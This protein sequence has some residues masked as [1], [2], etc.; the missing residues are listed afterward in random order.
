MPLASNPELRNLLTEIK[1]AH[2]QIIDTVSADRLLEAGPSPEATEKA[3]KTVAS[4]QEFIR[5][6]RDEITAL[7]VLYSRPYRQRLRNEDIHDL[8]DMLKSPPRGWTEQTLWDAYRR[9]DGS[10]VRGSG[11][12][13]LTDIV[14]LVR[15]AVGQDDELVPFADRVRERFAEWMA[16]Q[17]VNARPFTDEQRRWLEAIRDQIAASVSVGLDDLQLA[18]FAQWGGPARAYALFGDRLQPLLDEL[19]R[20]LVA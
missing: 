5:Q 8:A 20:E 1:R 14:S 19:N 16:R 9:L 3:R 7:Q 12:R 13:I 10:K 11:Q 4:F 15:F 18:P 2:E 6:H 17:E